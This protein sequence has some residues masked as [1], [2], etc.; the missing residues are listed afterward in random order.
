MTSSRY[1]RTSQDKSSRRLGVTL[2]EGERNRLSSRADR[3]PRG[4]HALPEGPVLLEQAHGREHPDRARLLPTGGGPG[5]RLF[6]RLGWYRRHLDLS[7]LVQPLGA[8]RDVPE[9][10]ER[11]H[12]CVGVRQHARGG[13]RFAGAH[14]P[15]VRPRLGCCRARVSSGNRAQPQVPNRAPLVRGVLVGDGSARRSAATSADRP[16]PRSALAHHPNLDGFTVLL[17]WKV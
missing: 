3:E 10:E 7:W 11:C 2:L 16:G 13:A 4:V 9:G 17:R 6:P 8:T 15:R 5:S 14:S 1:S 12:A